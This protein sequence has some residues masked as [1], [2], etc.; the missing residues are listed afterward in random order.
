VLLF[1]FHSP[2]IA[3][4]LLSR[5]AASPSVMD[6]IWD[7]AAPL[8]DSI[9][10]QLGIK[11]DAVLALVAL[12]L[13]VYSALRALALSLRLARFFLKWGVVALIFGTVIAALT[14]DGLNSPSR[15]RPRRGFERWVPD[16]VVPGPATPE[17]ND[18]LSLLST[19]WDKAYSPPPAT[20]KRRRTASTPSTGAGQLSMP[21][22]WANLAVQYA[23][24]GSKRVW[25]SVIDSWS[26][27]EVKPRA[28][29][30]RRG[31][32]G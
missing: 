13:A 25:Q 27:E 8:L 22:D 12:A 23:T 9:R 5:T 18:W 2:S 21:A 28:R 26:E 10:S 7:Y 16:A 19:A 6:A 17:P 32:Q 29:P 1:F 24:G 14:G 31:K 4:T 15:A 3:V 30:K 20:N 11:L